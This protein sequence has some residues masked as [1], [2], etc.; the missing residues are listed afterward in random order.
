MRQVMFFFVCLVFETGFLF[1]LYR[2]GC[3]GTH[4]VDQ[5]DLKLR[6]LLGLRAC[7][8]TPSASDVLKNAYLKAFRLGQWWHL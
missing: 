8:T 2:P 5:A 6:N 7:S 4:F 1:S 3:P